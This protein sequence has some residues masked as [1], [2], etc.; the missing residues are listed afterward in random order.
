MDRRNSYASIRSCENPKAGLLLARVRGLTAHEPCIF[1]RHMSAYASTFHSHMPCNRS[2]EHGMLC[3]QTGHYRVC[4]DCSAYFDSHVCSFMCS[5]M[6]TMSGWYYKFRL[7]SANLRCC[8]TLLTKLHAKRCSESQ[9]L[10]I[11]TC[12]AVRS[13]NDVSLQV[14]YREQRRVPSLPPPAS[15]LMLEL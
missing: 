11:H 3:G 4:F 1:N 13:E 7:N 8:E 5:F 2:L 6:E 15:I 9:A 12:V 14:Q 10:K